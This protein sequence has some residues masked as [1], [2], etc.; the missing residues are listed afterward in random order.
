MRDYRNTAAYQHARGLLAHVYAFTGRSGPGQGAEAAASVTSALRRAAIG[1]AASLVEGGAARS[2]G[3][4]HRCLLRAK[5]ALS[6]FP[7]LVNLCQLRDQLT[8]QTARLLLSEQAE[9][10]AA[11]EGLIAEAAELAS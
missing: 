3:D 5:T 10:S 4:Y 11:L 6:E 8:P 9:A 2:D 1:A 7:R